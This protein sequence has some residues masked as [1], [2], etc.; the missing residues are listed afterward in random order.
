LSDF[1]DIH[2][3]L[4][5]GLD[6]G[7][8]SVEDSVALAQAMSGL[9]IRTAHPTPHQ[10][11]GS[12]T[13]SAEQRQQAHSDLQA[14]L[15]AASCDLEVGTPAG[16]NMWDSLFL[17]RSDELCFPHYE[18]NKAFLIEFPLHHLP[19][20]LPQRLFNYRVRRVLPVIAHVERFPDLVNKPDRLEQLRG[21]AALLV[22]LSTLGGLGG[23]SQRR[24]AK[25]LVERGDA[26]AVTTDAHGVPDIAAS[27]KG[28]EW[29]DKRLGSREIDRL[30]RDNPRAILSG[31]I[32]D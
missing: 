8:E 26:H 6:D 31:E 13:P 10:K 24:L 28:L 14:A 1:I 4:L 3:H 5:F 22:N 17:E 7:P 21:K 29:L 32:P 25:K 16:E 2:N 20:Q 27:Q 15:K 12:W 19:A 23:W 18:G 30:M 11:V 9:G